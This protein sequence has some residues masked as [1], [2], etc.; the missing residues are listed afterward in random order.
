MRRGAPWGGPVAAP[1]AGLLLLLLLAG[2]GLGSAGAAPQRCAGFR[3]RVLW[4]L[5]ARAPRLL[6][7]MTPRERWGRG[8]GCD[9]RA[10]G[11]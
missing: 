9:V 7:R 3:T 1:L 4:S 11:V 10:A 5:A 6:A 2:C 8:A